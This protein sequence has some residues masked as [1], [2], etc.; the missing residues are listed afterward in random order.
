MKHSAVY[1]PRALAGM[2]ALYC[3][4]SM[5]PAL[6]QEGPDSDTVTAPE[7]PAPAVRDDTPD[8]VPAKP[9]ANTDNTDSPFDYRSSEEISEDLSVSFPVDI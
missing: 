9:D 1:K 4:C 3:A 6:A 8:P 2:L 5:T 7:T